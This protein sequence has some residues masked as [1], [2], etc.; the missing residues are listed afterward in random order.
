[1]KDRKREVGGVTRQDERSYA[2]KHK[3]VDRRACTSGKDLGKGGQP[4]LAVIRELILMLV[5]RIH[6]RCRGRG[7]RPEQ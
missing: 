7:R 3:Q 4:I 1:M 5:V 2:L 6:R